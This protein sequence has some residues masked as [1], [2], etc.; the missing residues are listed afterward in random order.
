MR[1][2]FRITKTSVYRGWC[3]IKLDDNLDYKDKTNNS[4]TVLN[5]SPFNKYKAGD[6]IVIDTEI[7]AG[8]S[9]SAIFDESV[10]SNKT[11]LFEK[12]S[13]V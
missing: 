7:V 12:N 9:Q 3:L 10:I 11:I 5:K 4:I 6:D 13:E 1:K 2:P 8:S